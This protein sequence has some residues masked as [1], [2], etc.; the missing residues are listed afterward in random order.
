MLLTTKARLT[1][2]PGPKIPDLG[3][4]LTGNAGAAPKQKDRIKVARIMAS[5]GDLTEE[6]RAELAFEVGKFS[7]REP[8]R[9]SNLGAMSNDSM[10]NDDQRRRAAS[11][12]Q[13]DSFNAQSRAFWADRI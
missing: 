8:S 4:L 9:V 13:A 12:R 1:A 10:L 6:E 11:D 7:G 2:E 5:V 3:L